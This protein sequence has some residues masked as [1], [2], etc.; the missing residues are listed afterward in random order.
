MEKK[1]NKS[2]RTVVDLWC[3]VVIP[4]QEGRY[5]GGGTMKEPE[6]FW[7]LITVASVLAVATFV[8]SMSVDWWGN[9]VSRS[10]IITALVLILLADIQ[11]VRD[12][13]R[14]KAAGIPKSDERLDK[15]VVYAMAYS[16]RVGIFF[17]IVLIF[18]HLLKVLNMDLVVALSASVF[19]MAGAYVVSYWYF[20]KKGDAQ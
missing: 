19:V 7:P 6:P 9:T 14:K 20:D 15:V 10:A 1:R 2:G 18:L 4:E 5:T 13:R 11:I 16:F 12:Y 3:V 8:I 17:M